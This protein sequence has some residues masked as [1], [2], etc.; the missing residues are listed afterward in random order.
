MIELKNADKFRFS[1]DRAKD[2]H[3]HEMFT[4]E[5]NKVL[6]VTTI[7]KQFD[8]DGWKFAWPV[9]LM[10]EYVK[11]R[12]K[13]D[14]I[15]FQ[16]QIDATL[17]EGKNAW[18]EKR[19][20]AGDAGVAGHKHIERWIAD[21]TWPPADSGEEIFNVFNQFLLW[22]EKNNPEW[23]ASE[24]QV[25][26]L[27]HEYAGILDSLCEIEGVL[28]LVDFKTGKDVKI[29]KKV[30]PSIIAQLAGLQ[31]ALEEQGVKPLKRAV[32]HL[33]L[34]GEY[35]FIPV[36][37]DIEKDKEDFIGACVGLKSITRLMGRNGNA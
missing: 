29:N 20:K 8:G 26:S 4:G 12:W 21:G 1:E 13:K 30:K 22:G 37:T 34:K 11:A 7:A 23:K 31:L 36:E 27:T 33:P 35:E 14:T 2:I 17:K 24:L 9:K 25:G 3:L 19:D 16:N 28:W 6:G 15:Y 32:L 18:R 5:W 10:E